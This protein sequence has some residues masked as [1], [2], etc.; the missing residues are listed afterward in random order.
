MHS[1]VQDPKLTAPKIATELHTKTNQDIL[2]Q[3]IRRIIKSNGCNSRAARNKPLISPINKRKRLE[4]ALKNMHAPDN[5]WADVI[6][7]DESKFN[8]FGSDGNVKVWWKP[9]TELEWKNFF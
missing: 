8:I 2:S 4:F 7:T 5:F 3:T 9:N 6:F 1:I